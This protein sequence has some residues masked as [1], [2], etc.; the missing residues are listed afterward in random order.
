MNIKSFGK[1][2]FTTASLILFG[3]C[4][5]KTENTSTKKL[6]ADAHLHPSNYTDQGISLRNLLDN[7]LNHPNTSIAR[8]AVMPLPLHQRWDG[9]EGYQ[10]RDPDRSQTV[11]ANYYIGPKADLYY[12]SFTDAMYAKEYLKLSK[13]HQDKVDLMITGFNPMDIY[14]SQHIKRAI[15]TF[16]GAFAGIGEF[17]VHKELVSNKLAGEPIKSTAENEKTPP[18]VSVDEKVSLYSDSL[19]HLLGTAGKIGLVVT[20]HNDIYPAEVDHNGNVIAVYPEKPYTDGLLWLCRKAPGTNVIWAHT[21][22]G[23]YI[24]PTRNHLQSVSK[25]LETCPNW[26]IDISWTLVQDVILNPDQDMPPTQEWR[27]FMEK[28]NNRILWGSDT[29]LYGRN[30]FET[31][32]NPTDTSSDKSHYLILTKKG[33]ALTPKQYHDEVSIIQELLD[34]LSDATAHNIRY[35]NYIRIFDAAKI[36]IRAWEEEHASDNIWDIPVEYNPDFD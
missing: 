11:G 18:D 8:V 31:K 7:Y 10:A 3:G 36:K 29:V 26:S 14:A 9:F 13:K 5:I 22:L 25:I 12:Y 35:G 33:S 4:A 20:L 19:V 15:L 17:T 6:L 24:K 32:Q 23:R 21:G 16:P 1:C 30:Q 2:L 28:Y 27:N 34:S